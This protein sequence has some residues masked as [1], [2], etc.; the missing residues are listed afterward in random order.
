MSEIKTIYFIDH[1]HTDIGYTDHQDVVFQ[2]HMEFI[3]EAIEACEATGDFPTDAQ[4]RWTC[5]AT[6]ITETLSGPGA[7]RA[8]RPIHRA[9]PAGPHGRYGNVLQLHLPH[10]ARSP[11]AQSLSDSPPARPLRPVDRGGHAV[12]RKRYSVDVRRPAANRG[13]ELPCDGH[14]PDARRHAVAASGSLLVGGPSGKRLGVWNGYTYGWGITFW[15]MG[16]LDRF[17]RLMPQRIAE[18]EARPDY[19][20]EF[21][22]VQVTHPQAVDN[23]PPYRVLSEFARDWNEA[24][25]SPRLVF[26]TLAEFGRSMV[27]DHMQNARSSAATGST[28]GRTARGRPRTRRLSTGGLPSFCLRSKR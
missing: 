2:K 6:G 24:G 23:G 1:N 27:S 9:P 20:Y 14:K 13:R 3:D 10:R 26:T 11:A 28:G 21:V 25:N 19:P 16:D 22:F 4:F 5:E 18:L 8:D 15:G 7:A 12:R 17:S